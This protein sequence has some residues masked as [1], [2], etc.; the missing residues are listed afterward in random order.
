MEGGSQG[1]G[2]RPIEALN[3]QFHHPVRTGKHLTNQL[4]L[5][6]HR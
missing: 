2:A 3:P 1:V 4:T 5:H 6:S